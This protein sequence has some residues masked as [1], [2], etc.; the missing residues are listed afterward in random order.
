MDPKALGYS[1]KVKALTLDSDRPRS[2]LTQPVNSYDRCG[3]LS[4]SVL[5]YKSESHFMGLM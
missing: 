1:F 2:D 4:V 5:T 3:S